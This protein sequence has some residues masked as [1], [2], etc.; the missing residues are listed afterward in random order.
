MN[1]F[2]RYK[3]VFLI[4][5]FFAVVFAAGYFLW[6]FFFKP[7]TVIIPSGDVTGALSGLPTAGL[8]GEIGGDITGAGNLPGDGGI[9]PGPG[10]LTGSGSNPNLPSE[11]A[12]GGLT[13]TELAAN[14]PILNPTTSG[15]GQVQ[16]YNP[17]DGKFYRLDENGQAT[18]MSDTVFHN[19]NN[20]VWA[21]DKDRA[22]LKYPDGNKILYN[23]S[24]EKQVTLPKHW[25][26]FSFAPSSDKIV[27]KSIGLDPE[28]RWLMVSN[29]DGSNAKAIEA[30]GTNADTVYPSWSP[31]NQIV[32]MYTKGIDFDRQEVFF[33]GLNEENFKSTIIEGR[34]FQSQ[35]SEAGNNLLYSVYHSRDDL[36]PR[37]WIVNASSDTIG[38]N[39]QSL[40][41][42]TWANKCTFASETE[43]Y[44]AVP[45]TL[46]RG[47]GLFPELADKTKDSLY[48]IDLTTGAKQL[49][50]VPDGAYNVS[51]IVVPGDQNYLYFTDKKTDLMYKVKLK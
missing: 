33:L 27:S 41:L 3:K 35:W 49:I 40:D 47:A 5:L 2:A 29:E 15:S 22:I 39:R 50:A 9:T 24:T 20:V 1:F 21:P 4:L 8:G 6:I 48:R 46:E 32:A 16:Y 30:I 10:G 26:D 44:C 11:V 7:T 25:E 18:L 12:E 42:Q 45:D 14:V 51:Q 31:N 36:K 17:I 43:I 23:F 38:Q 34:G 13:K 28:N 37:L 19:V